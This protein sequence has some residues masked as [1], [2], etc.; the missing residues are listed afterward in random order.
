MK[1]KEF[2]LHFALLALI[3]VNTKCERDPINKRPPVAKAG[4]DIH[5]QFPSTTALLD[6]TQSSDLDRNISSYKWTKISGPPLYQIQ[7][8][9]ARRTSVSDLS[10]GT[11]EFE[12]K[13]TDTDSLFSKDTV[14]IINEGAPIYGN[15]EVIFPNMLWD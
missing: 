5:I 9:H 1:I 13:V 15:N 11:Y 3:L 6:G 2:R 4:P 10:A 7:D 8:P 12:L 14:R